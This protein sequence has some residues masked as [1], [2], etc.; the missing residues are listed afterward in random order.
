ML[1]TTKY[2]IRCNRELPI[3]HFHK[4]KHQKDG[5]RVYCKDCVSEYGKEYRH[6]AAGVYQNLRGK[7]RWQKTNRVDRYK[8]VTITQD[9]FVEWYNSQPRVC[10][11]CGISEENIY[12]MND[13]YGCR[14]GRLTVDCKDNFVGYV[15][16]NIVL[17]CD[18]C[19]SVKNNVLTFDEMRYVGENFIKPKWQVLLNEKGEKS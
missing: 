19:N 11:Y 4:N 8:P 14:Y 13:K 6:T 1:E 5:H 16:G 3:I 2:C 15:S 12:L 17:A 18:K 7:Q 9:E 10:A